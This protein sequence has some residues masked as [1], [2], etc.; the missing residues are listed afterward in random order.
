MSML[1]ENDISLEKQ[2]PE[3]SVSKTRSEKL[4][5]YVRSH[6]YIAP[7][8]VIALLTSIFFF[9]SYEYFLSYSSKLAIPIM[10]LELPFTFYI[11]TALFIMVSIM[12]LGIIYN[13]DYL[14]KN[15]ISKR[16]ATI[17]LVSYIILY[18]I[19]ILL[20]Y[21]LDF[22]SF[23]SN[24]GMW[25][26]AGLI[27]LFFL[28]LQDMLISFKYKTLNDYFE[29]IFPLPNAFSIALFTIGIIF[30]VSS[31][32]QGI[33]NYEADQLIK[34]K[35]SNALE[36]SLELVNSTNDSLQNKTLFLIMI[37]NNAYYVIEKNETPKNDNKLYIIPI[38]QVKVATI[39]R[40]YYNADISYDN[41]MMKLKNISHEG[42][43]RSYLPKNIRS[44]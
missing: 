4:F 39:K 1:T 18:T 36:V 11:E 32:F 41:I 26:Y 16:A 35:S 7:S 19:T 37:Q 44:S 38:S 42:T 33:G 9:L 20:Y 43:L 30:I 2:T 27:F 31:V 12:Y 15:R 8:F 14:P 21:Y 40:H 29:K 3:N 25:F 22:F 24:L 23:S 34:G 28:F 13:F 6:E 17:R 5:E 10:G